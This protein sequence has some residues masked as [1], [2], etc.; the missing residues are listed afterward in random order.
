MSETAR[1]LRLSLVPL[2]ESGDTVD[3]R[4]VSADYGTPFP[5]DYMEYV[6]AFGAGTID[7]TLFVS[8]PR[9][10]IP[11]APL[12]VSRLPEEVLRGE[13]MDDWQRSDTASRPALSDVLL[14]GDT[15]A[16]DA[17]GWVT[18]DPDPDRWPVVVWARQ[19]GGWAVHDCG[20]STFLLRILRA[21]LEKCPISDT[22]LWG[23]GTARFL[24][25]RAERRLQ[26]EGIDPWTSEPDP[27][28]GMEFD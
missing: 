24:S 27:F 8:I 23:R 26:E 15:N 19:G 9:R 20:M 13:A 7:Q 12:T 1:Q 22:S 2:Y 10:G 3:W 4:A 21:E 25:L 14:W 16:A 5:A 11:A 17:L 6:G 28:A 18:T